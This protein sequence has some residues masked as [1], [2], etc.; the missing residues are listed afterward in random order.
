[1]KELSTILLTIYMAA[2]LKFYFD[3]FFYTRKDRKIRKA[4][5]WGIFCFWQCF[6]NFD[7]SYFPA[8]VNM[9]FSTLSILFIGLGNYKGSTWKKAVL[10]IAYAALWMVAETFTW[11]LLWM[12]MQ[13]NVLTIIESSLISNIFLSFLVMGICFFMKQ[14]KQEVDDCDG[15]TKLLVLPLVNILFCYV[16]YEISQE[17]GTGKSKV[18]FFL[19]IG[20]ILLLAVNFTVYR[21]YIKIIESV[22]GKRNDK[23]YIKQMDLYREQH[24]RGID[25]VNDAMKIRHDVKHQFLYLREVAKL[26]QD[27]RMEEAVTDIIEDSLQKGDVYVHTGNLAVDAIINHAMD[28][29]IEKKIQ[30][31]LDIDPLSSLTTEDRDLCIILGNAVNNALEAVEKLEEHL[32]NIWVE[33]KHQKGFLLINIKNQYKDEIEWIE[34]GERIKSTKGKKDGVHGIGLSSIRKIVNKYNGK[35]EIRTDQ[36]YFV[37]KIILHS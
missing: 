2:L 32:R 31:Q 23:F 15:D 10:S 21:I 35:M 28:L 13:R 9:I 27:R 5:I 17:A 4:A 24:Q 22:Q 37:L 14:K 11:V 6:I 12:L 33:I 36:S 30:I 8:G 18:R 16:L 3:I 25:F 19:F 29:V 34:Y 26:T 7:V 20:T 1:M